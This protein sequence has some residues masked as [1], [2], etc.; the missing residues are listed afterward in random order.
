MNVFV[1][2]TESD[3]A[4]LALSAHFSAVDR[5]PDLQRVEPQDFSNAGPE[6]GD[7]LI[8]GDTALDLIGISDLGV[9]AGC[10]VQYLSCRPP[11]SIIERLIHAGCLVAGISPVLAPRVAH[12]VAGFSGPLRVRGEHG[13]PTWG[14]VGVGFTGT[15]VAH[16]LK[17]SGSVVAISEIR[18]PRSQL[19]TEL[20]VRRQS[21]DLLMA[22]SDAITLHVYPGPT[23][24]PLVGE[25]ELNLMKSGAALINTS[26]SSVVDEHAVIDALSSGHLGGYAT[27]CAGEVV[28]TADESLKQ[29]GKLVVTTNPLTSQ[30]GAAQ[31]IARFVGANVQ[32]FADGI[33]VQGVIEL[34]DFP[35]IGDP[36]FWSSKMSPRQ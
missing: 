13:A 25:R 32:A 33:D 31:H 16:K 15:A 20:K 9:E 2:S 19:L 27:D 23:A 34:V 7:V 26:H 21:L 29:S 3:P 11:V 28:E 22:G 8:V 30:I 5:L 4:A 14:V 6:N 10:M 35:K 24:N 18:T 1:I 12:R 17:E 36:S